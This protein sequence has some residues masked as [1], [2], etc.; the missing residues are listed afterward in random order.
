MLESSE[1]EELQSKLVGQ[2][3]SVGKDKLGKLCI[4][5]KIQAGDIENKTLLGLTIILI[6]EIEKQVSILKPEEI[7]PFLKDCVAIAE[8][9]VA[10]QKKVGTDAEKERKKELEASIDALKYNRKKS[11]RP[12]V[13]LG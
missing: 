12:P 9:D 5:F 10:S 7:M 1:I 6:V 8:G 13:R 4:L 2:I 11:W 3:G